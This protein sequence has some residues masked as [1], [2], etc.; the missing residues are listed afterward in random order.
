MGGGTAAPLGP[1]TVGGA[2]NG[3]A[4]AV[5]VS[6]PS[7]KVPGIGTVACAMRLGCPAIADDVGASSARRALPDTINRQKRICRFTSE[8]V[9]SNDAGWIARGALNSGHGCGDAGGKAVLTEFWP[10]D[11]FE[12]FVESRFRKTG[13]EVRILRKIRNASTATPPKT[14][15]K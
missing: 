5:M 1:T 7:G 6:G 3:S 8:P 4:P 12:T 13:S 9:F 14:V 2:V 10:V 15:K 11:Q